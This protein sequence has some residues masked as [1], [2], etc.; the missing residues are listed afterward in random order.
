MNLFFAV[1]LFEVKVR[2]LIIIIIITMII[3]LFH[4]FRFLKKFVF[5]EE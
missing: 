4:Y 1:K 2:M 5:I 3:F